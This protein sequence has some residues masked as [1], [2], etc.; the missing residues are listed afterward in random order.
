MVELQGMIPSGEGGEVAGNGSNFRLRFHSADAQ[1][2]LALLE[3]VQPS[4]K[5]VQSGVVL[6]LGCPTVARPLEYG[7]S[8]IA[9]IS[10]PVAVS[11]A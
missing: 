11:S 6:R 2:V 4:S 1:S 7:C 10:R 5:M 3:L 9:R 8:A